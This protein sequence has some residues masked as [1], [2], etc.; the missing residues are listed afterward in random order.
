MR[1]LVLVESPAKCNKILEI[2]KKHSPTDLFYVEAT[3]GHVTELNSLEQIDFKTFTY[4]P[5]IIPGKRKLLSRIRN[6]AKMVNEI[7]FFMDAD[8]EGEGIAYSLCKI[9]CIPW[10]TAKRGIFHEITEKAIIDAFSIPSKID[11]SLVNAQQTRQIIDLL[12]GFQISPIL[13]RNFPYTP[14][15]VLSA[16]RCQIP[17]LK[18]IYER[19]IE[20]Q[21]NPPEIVYKVV[22]YFTNKN[23]PFVLENFVVTEEDQ[24]RT[25]LENE[26]TFHHKYECSDSTPII[27][28]VPTPLTTSTLLQLAYN[29]LSFSPKDTMKYAQILYEY[30]Y[31]TYIRTDNPIYNRQFCKQIENFIIRRWGE[32]YYGIPRNVPR[33][34]DGAHEA[35][36]PTDITREKI[37]DIINDKKVQ[38]LYHLIW[39]HVVATGMTPAKGNQIIAYITS[40]NG[41]KFIY[42][43]V[44]YH[45]LGWKQVFNEILTDPYYHY[46]KTITSGIILPYNHILAHTEII[47]KKPY[48]T[49]ANLI[50]LLEEKGIGRPSTYASIINKI[51]DR[52][53]VNI[54][55]IVGEKK[56][57][58]EYKLILD[59][60]D[61]EEKN[62]IMGEEKSK[63]IIQPIG[64]QVIEFLNKWFDEL[65]HYE[66]TKEME[67]DLDKIAKGELF[68]T[69]LC[70]SYNENIHKHITNLSLTL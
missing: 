59:K 63:L 69:I 51:I 33:N 56:I 36:R 58:K 21:A 37:D 41:N 31:I 48:Y 24:L 13:W 64:I 26:K 34:I 20:R 3:R 27:L 12:I 43:S 70:A 54:E 50:Q 44:K 1:Y 5:N 49:E 11:I 67:K 38:K 30:G 8:R 42:K 18:L 45:F 19:E 39:Q 61:V 7:L 40:S 6:I 14:G 4:K 68:Y 10:K 35:I 55:N 53:Y 66:Y 32:E 22:G 57:C 2:L 15:E 46:L 62:T 23:I 60:I 52:N 17:A 16:G 29:K 9:L 28:S 47:N 65:F 25:F